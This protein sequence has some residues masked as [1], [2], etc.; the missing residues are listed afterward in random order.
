MKRSIS[1]LCF[2]FLLLPFCAPPS[3]GMDGRLTP[4]IIDTTTVRV[5]ISADAAFDYDLEEIVFNGIPVQCI[6]DIKLYQNVRYWFDKELAART[7]HHVLT[8]DNL[9]DVF[10]VEYGTE[11]TAPAEVD[12]LKEAELLVVNSIENLTITTQEVLDA[13]RNYYIVYKVDVVADTEN[14]H[15]PFYLDYLLNI[16]PWRNK[17]TDRN[18]FSFRTSLYAYE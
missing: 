4:L 3:Y 16:F 8:Y 13:K 9:K 1:F 18:E 10:I 15:L 6:F 17:K 12:D 14:S 5:T 7:I 11:N 2:L